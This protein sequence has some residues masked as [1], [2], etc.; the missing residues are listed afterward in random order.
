[1]PAPHSGL[2]DKLSGVKMYLDVPGFQFNDSMDPNALQAVEEALTCFKAI[3]LFKNY[4]IKGDADR[5]LIYLVL[6]IH[7]CLMELGQT[8]PSKDAAAKQLET[9]AIQCTVIPGDSSFPLSAFYKTGY[10]GDFSQYMERLRKETNKRLIEKVYL[11]SPSAPSKWWLAF[12]KR[13]F[14]NQQLKNS[15]M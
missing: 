6:Y 10:P 3:V 13:K 2:N 1:M 7:R 11:E 14:M 4:E 8:K 5:L 9:L 15:R 12:A